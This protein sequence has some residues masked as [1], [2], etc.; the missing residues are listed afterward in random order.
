MSTSFKEIKEWFNEGKKKGY[1]YMTVKCDTFDYEDYPVY[2]YSFPD[3][4]HEENMQRVHEIYDLEKDIYSQN[5]NEY[6]KY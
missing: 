4:P 6:F 1:K 2:S 5:N 3:C